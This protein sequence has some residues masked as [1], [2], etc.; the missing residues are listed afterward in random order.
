VVLLA[1]ADLHGEYKVYEWM[2]EVAA[3]IQPDVLLLAGD[4]LGFPDGYDD[5]VMAQRAD[6]RAILA[7]ME[8][9]E[10][11]VFY[12]MGNGDMIEL[13]AQSDT[14]R[15]IHSVRVEMQPYNFVGYQYS[16]SFLG[17]PFEKGESAMRADLLALSPLIDERTI[18]V[19]HSPAYGILDRGIMSRHA[20]SKSLKA[21]ID[22]CSPLLHIHGHS[23][24]DAGRKDIHINVAS[25]FHKRVTLIDL[26]NLRH[27]VIT[28][29][30][31]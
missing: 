12:I 28:A 10:A 29:S 30:M 22:R 6:A 4:L 31:S 21:F 26:E 23:H 8:D 20:G 11:Q 13:E 2:A 25:A 27:E 3:R 17:R 9:I 18:F 14:I 1:I 24:M 16:P 19:T 7:I 5:I 15:S